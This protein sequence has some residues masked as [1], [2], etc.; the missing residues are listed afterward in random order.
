MGVLASIP[1]S[2]EISDNRHR[3]FLL[4]SNLDTLRLSVHRHK[5]DTSGPVQLSSSQMEEEKAA[6]WLGGKENLQSL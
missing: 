4:L 2:G 1:S 5:T 6:K 3:D